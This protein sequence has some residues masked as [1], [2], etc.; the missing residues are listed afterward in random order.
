[1]K[2]T[3]TSF[4]RPALAAR[5]IAFLVLLGAAS[6]LHAEI[7][8]GA[9]DMR[10][11]SRA[12]AY[13]FSQAQLKTMFDL[14]SLQD[15]MLA[16]GNCEGE[17]LVKPQQLVILDPVDLPDDRDEAIKGLWTVAYDLVRC[18][19]AKRYNVVWRARSDGSAPEPLA[20]YPGTTLVSLQLLRDAVVGALAGVQAKA[21]ATDCTKLPTIFDMRVDEPPHR[22]EED[23]KVFERVWLETWTFEVC[24]K[25]IDAHMTFTSTPGDG[26]TDWHTTYG[27]ATS[28]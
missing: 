5:R 24:G 14:G 22:V 28:P 17:V 8:R 19:E 4:A 11:G 18:N 21:K 15:R 20:H 13:F 25:R 9:I 27:D 12:R 23:G 2:S 3:C 10:P 6:T 1:M 26:G 16:I 7:V